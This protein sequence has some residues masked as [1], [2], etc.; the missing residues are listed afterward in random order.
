M[1]RKYMLIL[2]SLFFLLSCAAIHNLNKTDKSES[3][4]NTNKSGVDFGRR[5]LGK[6]KIYITKR[7]S[8]EYSIIVL[9]D[10]SLK[11]TK[12]DKDL[13]IQIYSK[14]LPSKLSSTIVEYI[15]SLGPFKKVLRYKKGKSYKKAVILEGRF[16]KI[17]RGSFVAMSFFGA[18]SSTVGIEGVLKDAKT[19]KVLASFK[20]IRHST[21]I[22]TGSYKYQLDAYTRTLAKDIVRFLQKL[23]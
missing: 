21:P 8:T 11:K 12:I 22:A 15:R 2:L 7:L 10:F 13:D 17:A 20:Q 14:K 9:K 1:V 5:V 23:Y 19:D 3:E 4:V 18:G 6:E 16:T